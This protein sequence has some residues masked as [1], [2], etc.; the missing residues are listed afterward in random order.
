MAVVTAAALLASPAW[1]F[2]EHGGTETS[3]VTVPGPG[4]A[5]TQTDQL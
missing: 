2:G 5:T 4:N 1:A 3:N